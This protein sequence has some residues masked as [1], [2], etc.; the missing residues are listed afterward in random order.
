MQSQLESVEEGEANDRAAFEESYYSLAA[1]IRECLGPSV[2]SSRDATS[3][4]SVSNASEQA[5]HVQLP[6]LNLPRFSG[7]YDEWFPFYDAF[8]SII[9]SNVS[10]NNVQ[11]LQYFRGC[12]SGEA[13]DV[14]S[15]LE[16]SDLNYDVAWRLLRERYDNKRITVNAHIKAIDEFPTML[17]ENV[18]ELRQIVDGATKH[19]HAL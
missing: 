8:N 17:K 12:L 10:L 11:R 19:I 15:S 13:S 4:P 7:K 1:R 14:V 16:I 2:S 5:T 18:S 9:H 6:K 3:S